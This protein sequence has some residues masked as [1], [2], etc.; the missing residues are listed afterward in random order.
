MHRL[1]CMCAH[2]TCVCC[3]V[4]WCP[5]CVLWCGVVWC[6]VVWCGVS[7][8][9]SAPALPPH[10]VHGAGPQ[11]PG[12]LLVSVSVRQCV[13]VCGL[14]C[15]LVCVTVWVT[16][17]VSVCV[18]LTACC[19]ALLL[20]LC[21]CIVVLVQHSTAAYPYCT[22]RPSH[23]PSHRLSSPLYVCA[24]LCVRVYVYVCVCMCV[25]VCVCAGASRTRASTAP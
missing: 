21:C 14:L 22:Y 16:V 6:G 2:P 1:H 11:P 10:A 12:E 4:A 5:P 24:C 18:L 13:L 9:L 3:D 17:C 7:Q 25:C 15:A 23:P 19:R 8:V 20:L